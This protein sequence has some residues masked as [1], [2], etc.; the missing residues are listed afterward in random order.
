[1]G[2]I[3]DPFKPRESVLRPRPGGGK[4]GQIDPAAAWRPASASQPRPAEPEPVPPIAGDLLGAGLNPLVRAASPLLLLA[5]R[6][7]GTLA[8]GDV[9]SVRQLALSEIREFE[10]RAQAA[11]ISNDLVLAARYALCA[12]MDEAVLSTPWGAQ[13]E[14]SQQTL[15]V[16]LHREAWGGEKFFDMLERTSREPARYIDLMELQYVCIAVGFCGKY[17]VMERG[18]NQLAEVQHELYRRIREHRGAP[19]TALS[20][21]WEGLQD[22]RNPVIRYVPW[23]VVGAATLAVLATAFTLYYA[24][25]ARAAGPIQDRLGAVAG[26]GFAPRPAAPRAGPTLKQLLASD[27]AAGALKVEEDGGRTVITLAG[28]TLFAS[29][30]ATVDPG[31]AP[32]LQRVAAALAQVPGRVL[33]EGHTDDQPLRSIR[34]SDNVQLSRERAVSVGTI[35]QSTP[36]NAGR[37]TVNGRG[38][39]QPR[40]VPAS[41]PANRALNR[42]VEI[43]HVTGY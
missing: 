40:Y 16:V 17:H 39:S 25:L 26:E 7:R 9:G 1:M 41:D 4:R 38:S 32:V 23:W 10:Q 29:G 37:I 2:D 11:G 30:S 27:E 31:Y 34:Y 13:S 22:R 8:V 20:L 6:L 24:A 21:R 35:L 43:L 15:L 28:G 3:D 36:G 12:T 19:Q 33:V 14:W 5:G 42:R 18:L